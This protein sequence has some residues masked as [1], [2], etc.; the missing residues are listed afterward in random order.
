MRVCVGGG[1]VN[2]TC[3]ERLRGTGVPWVH[4]PCGSEGGMGPA[5]RPLPSLLLQCR[6]RLGG[7][8][9]MPLAQVQP[10]LGQLADPPLSKAPPLNSNPGRWGTP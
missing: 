2:A 3:Q 5:W 9:L 6:A 7:E 4:L 8:S 10:G 1:P